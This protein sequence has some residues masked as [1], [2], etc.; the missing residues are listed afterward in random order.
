MGRLTKSEIEQQLLSGAKL[1]WVEPSKK[2]GQAQLIDAEQR[3][4]FQFLLTSRVRQPT[5][6]PAN[7]VEGL[8]TAFK[9]T[10]DPA[11][12]ASGTAGGAAASG[13]WRLQS[14]ETETSAD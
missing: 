14:I 11:A 3:R 12:A 1:T 13:P 4:L 10:D 5:G 7:F 2:G 9:A 6:L 8:A